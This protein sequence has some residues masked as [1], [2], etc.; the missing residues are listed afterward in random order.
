MSMRT[1]WRWRKRKKRNWRKS[2]I[3][4]RTVV[5]RWWWWWKDDGDEEVVVVGM[6]IGRGYYCSCI[7]S[8]TR[9]SFVERGRRPTTRVFWVSD[10]I[11]ATCRPLD[12]CAC[13]N[14]WSLDT[15]DHPFSDV[16]SKSN[17]RMTSS[18]SVRVTI[19]P[20]LYVSCRGSGCYRTDIEC[21]YV[22]LDRNR[23]CTFYLAPQQENDTEKPQN[24]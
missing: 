17:Q 20:I 10:D 3:G 4:R 7:L 2:S 21:R 16:F 12:A 8:V 9:G 1:N 19:S 18:V 24:N 14:S 23:N 5:T 11:D 13:N 6:M 22:G 15:R